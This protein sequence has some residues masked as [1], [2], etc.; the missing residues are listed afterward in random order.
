[1]NKK[2]YVVPMTGANK[3]SLRCSLLAG[4]IT[5]AQRRAGVPEDTPHINPNPLQD[6]GSFD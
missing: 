4:S 5:D 2:V 1:M 3:A 6:G